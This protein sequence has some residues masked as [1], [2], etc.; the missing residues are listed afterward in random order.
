ML[1]LIILNKEYLSPQSSENKL[2]TLISDERSDC[3]FLKKDDPEWQDLDYCVE[4]RNENYLKL[5]AWLIICQHF[6]MF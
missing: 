5:A 2:E 4:V 1:L 3:K 6:G